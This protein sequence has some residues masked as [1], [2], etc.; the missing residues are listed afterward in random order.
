[1]RFAYTILYVPSVE[2]TLDFYARAFGFK[3]K[4]IHEGGD[5]GEL[6]T[7]TTVLAFSAL[8]LMRQLGKSPSAANAMAPCFE[9]AFTTEDVSS[10]MNKAVLAGAVRMAEPVQ[11]P[12][13]QTIGYVADINGFLI[14]ICTPM[15][16]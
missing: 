9:L 5:Y 10:A 1:V 13:G 14:E 2:Q 3:R 8:T 12:W 11:M 15:S 7:G 4:F 16:N 6:D